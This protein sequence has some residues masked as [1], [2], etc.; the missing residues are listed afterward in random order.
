MKR[1]LTPGT[2]DP[3]TS[4][5]LDVITRAAQLVDEVV[6]AVAASPK[7]NP[8]FTLEERTELVR[9]ATAHLPNVRVEPFDEL[10]VTFAR[11]MDA[12]VVVKGLR[13][14]TDFEYEFQMTAIN[15][16]LSPALET[17]F[18]MSPP[19]YMY[20]SSSVVR[21]VASLGGDVSQFVPPCVAR[22]CSEVATASGTVT[23]APTGRNVH[24]LCIGG[25]SSRM[26]ARICDACAR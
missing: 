22:R 25:W 18:I 14:I 6:V 16:Q 23:C 26:H 17:L 12:T 5:H 1:A 21:E 9:Q 4:G 19:Q 2:F 10:L 8:L 7:K 3:V 15:Y 13:A 24:A 20:L 11:K